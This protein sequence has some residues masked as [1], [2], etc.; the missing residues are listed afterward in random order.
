LLDGYPVVPTRILHYATFPPHGSTVCTPNICIAN[1]SQNVSLSDML[2]TDSLSE[3][4]NASIQLCQCQ[5]PAIAN[6]KICM[7]QYGQTVS[8]ERM[9]YK[10][11]IN[12]YQC[13]I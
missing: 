10:Q 5:R 6:P 3:L 12:I 7:T 13:P 2:T 8:A 11:I 4:T 9:Y 1:C